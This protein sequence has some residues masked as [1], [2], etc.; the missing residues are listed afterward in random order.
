MN[1]AL[2]CGLVR[3]VLGK[4]KVTWERPALQLPVQEAGI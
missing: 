4:Q 3:I 1:Y 2:F